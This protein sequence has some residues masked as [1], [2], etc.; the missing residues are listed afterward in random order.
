MAPYLERVLYSPE[1]G[2][3]AERLLDSLEFR[4]EDLDHRAAVQTDEVVVMTVAEDVFV[5]GVL[6][7]LVDL[8]DEAAFKEQRKGPVYRGPRNPD[9]LF[10][11]IAEKFFGIEMAVA[12]EDLMKD[13]PPLIRKLEAL[14]AEKFLEYRGLHNDYSK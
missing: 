6:V 8:F 4:R 2:F 7:V 3:P 5:M 12:G 13:R 1:A 9:I 10:L 14:L 11:H